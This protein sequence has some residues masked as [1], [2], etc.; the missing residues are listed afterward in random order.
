MSH[1]HG[2]IF[3]VE[4][5]D[6]DYERAVRAFRKAGCDGPFIRCADGTQAL[7]YLQTFRNNGDAEAPPRLILLD[8]NLPGMDGEQVLAQV[9]T[10]SAFDA[11]PIIILSASGEWD[12]IQ[13]C[14]LAGANAYVRKMLGVEEFE[15]TVRRITGY[16]LDTLVQPAAQAQPAFAS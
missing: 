2:P 12:D 7:A 13:R 10:T 5:S 4:D 8:I 14:Y 15:R 1:N 16:W 11:V 9:R 3:V 6:A